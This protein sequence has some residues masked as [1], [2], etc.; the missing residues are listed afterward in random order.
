MRQ[1]LIDTI[2]KNFLE[3]G[4]DELSRGIGYCSNVGERW[5]VLDRWLDQFEAGEINLATFLDRLRDEELLSMFEAQMCQR[6]R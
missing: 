4:L 2:T 5:P 1:L 6:Y 3:R